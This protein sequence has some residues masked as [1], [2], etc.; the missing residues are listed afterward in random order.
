MC[1][2]YDFLSGRYEQ[3]PNGQHVCGL[4]GCTPVNPDGEQVNLDHKGGCGFIKMDKPVVQL[5]FCF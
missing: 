3:R 4:H 1:L 5:N 2:D